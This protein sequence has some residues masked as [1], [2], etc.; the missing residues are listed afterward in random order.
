MYL[1]DSQRNWD[2]Y[3]CQDCDLVFRDPQTY[4]NSLTEKSRYETHENSMENKGYVQ[5]LSPVVESLVPFLHQG[6]CGL[7]YGSGPG[8]ILDI[9]FKEQGYQV[10]NY[11]PFFNN[12]PLVLKKSFQFVTCTEAIEHFYKPHDDLKMILS[13]LDTKGYLVLMTELNSGK[14]TFHNWY[15]R[16]DETHVCFLSHKTLDWI[17]KNLGLERILDQKRLFIFRKK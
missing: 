1:T 8:P 5:F 16:N 17:A 9:L 15:Y 3:Q 6:D 13:V 7:D 12:D 4:L 14:E 10:F 11:D 2:Y